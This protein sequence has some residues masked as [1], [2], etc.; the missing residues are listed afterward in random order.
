MTSPTT[1]TKD[2]KKLQAFV[3]AAL[4]NPKHPVYAMG[5]Q[6]SPIL[7][8]YAVNVSIMKSVEAEQWFKDYPEKTAKLERVMALCEAEEPA[9]ATQTEDETEK[10]RKE[11]A[12]LKAE[13][14]KLKTPPADANAEAEAEA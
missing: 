14:A 7:Q 3:E 13:L 8:H 12:D 1:P 4:T 2:F 9:A 11:N 5:M 10:L 6:H